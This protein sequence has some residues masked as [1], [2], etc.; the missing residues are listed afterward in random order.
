MRTPAVEIRA[1]AEA[2][3]RAD[4]AQLRDEQI[5]LITALKAEHVD[6]PPLM[7]LALIIEQPSHAVEPDD[8]RGSA[9]RNDPR[10]EP[11]EFSVAEAHHCPITKQ[12]VAIT[13]DSAAA[14]NDALDHLRLR[15]KHWH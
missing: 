5:A 8:P 11:E 2:A 3:H 7:R 4:R 12:V 13:V 1:V 14:R 9:Y 6:P 10:Q 15:P